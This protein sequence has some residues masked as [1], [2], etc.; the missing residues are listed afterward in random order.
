M[1]KVRRFPLR[2]AR[3][4]LKIILLAF[5]ATAEAQQPINVIPVHQP[6]LA[7]TFPPHASEQTP[8]GTGKFVIFTR[9]DLNKTG[10]W[11]FIAGAW[12]CIPSRTNLPITKRIEF[13]H[14][15]WEAWPLLGSLVD[16][17]HS[18]G[19]YPRFVRLQ[20]DAGN[21]DYSVNL[22]DINYRTWESRCVW[23]GSRLTA[24]GALKKTVICRSANEWF[25]L[26]AS[27]GGVRQEVACIPL[28]ADGDYWI[29][30]KNGETSGNWSYNPK[31]EEFVGHFRDIERPRV[32][33][34][35]SL[36]TPDGRSRAWILAP[37]PDDWRGGSLKGTFVLQRD[38]QN[39][40][41]RL[42]I[43]FQA[44]MGS[45]VPV[46]PTGISFQCMPG[47]SI[48]FA[49]QS[50]KPGTAEQVWTIEVAS[51]KTTETVRPHR[52]SAEPDFAT[53]D[54]V[55]SPE[56]LRQYLKN[57]RHFGRGGLAPA[58]LLHMGILKKQ[59]EFPDCEAGVSN[60]GRHI[61]YKAKKGSLS[62]VFIY[63]DTQTKR[64]LRWET[65]EALRSADSMEFV[66]V[67]TP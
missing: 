64:V 53:I 67:E 8:T 19:L 10:E 32:G 22:Y 28:E 57:L 60:D 49:A 43:T 56:Y 29:T 3:L 23:Q 9:E 5:V 38:G 6:P 24:F 12:E 54:G 17:E 35:R 62:N 18:K 39:E 45:G 21:A 36:V 11:D 59:P 66:W 20:V 37:M 14:S 30:R 2:L 13:C 34:T 15:S 51:G 26:D 40:D 52:A 41:I 46:I 42:P 31:K 48:E 50:E 33:C 47:G 1:T 55:P 61:L 58:F 44:R 16:D 27:T 4:N 63:G 7:K 25:S 65:P